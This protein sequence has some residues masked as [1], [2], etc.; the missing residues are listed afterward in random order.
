MSFLYD[1]FTSEILHKFINN[2]PFKQQKPRSPSKSPSK[3]STESSSKKGTPKS[4]KSPSK[5]SSPP[6][7]PS[8]QSKPTEEAESPAQLQETA[9]EEEAESPDA[10]GAESPDATETES[11]DAAE[12]ESPD[13]AEAES[14]DAAEA[15]ESELPQASPEE[16]DQ[17]QPP[18]EE[19]DELDLPPEESNQPDEAPE[20]P[21]EQ[22]EDSAEK[23]ETS[24]EKVE[25]IAKPPRHPRPPRDS[26][27][28]G[29]SC[30]ETEADECA[31]EQLGDMHFVYD[32]PCFANC[33]PYMDPVYKLYPDDCDTYCGPFTEIHWSEILIPKKV[34]LRSVKKSKPTTGEQLFAKMEPPQKGP[35]QEKQMQWTQGAPPTGDSPASELEINIGF[36]EIASTFMKVDGGADSQVT[37]SEIS[38]ISDVRMQI[39]RCPKDYGVTLYMPTVGSQPFVAA[40]PGTEQIAGLMVA[41]EPFTGPQESVKGPMKP[42]PMAR[43][44][45]TLDDRPMSASMPNM[46]VST[47]NSTEFRNTYPRA[48]NRPIAAD[49]YPQGQEQMMRAVDVEQVAIIQDLSTPAGSGAKNPPCYKCGRKVPDLQSDPPPEA[50]PPDKIKDELPK[51][52]EAEQP[53]ISPIAPEGSYTCQPCKTYLSRQADYPDMKAQYPLARAD[54]GNLS[55]F[56]VKS[57]D[58]R[59]KHGIPPPKYEDQQCAGLY[60]YTMPQMEERPSKISTL[61]AQNIQ[62]TARESTSSPGV[63][64]PSVRPPK[65]PGEEPQKIGSTAFTPQLVEGVGERKVCKATCKAKMKSERQS[66]EKTLEGVERKKKP[67]GGTCGKRK[68]EE[69]KTEPKPVEDLARDMKTAPTKSL[70]KGP[71]AQLINIQDITDKEMKSINEEIEKIKRKIQEMDIPELDNWRNVETKTCPSCM[72]DH[73]MRQYPAHSSGRHQYAAAPYMYPTGQYPNQYPYMPDYSMYGP[74]YTYPYYQSDDTED[75]DFVCSCSRRRPR[76]R[77][78]KKRKRRSSQSITSDISS[79]SGGSKRSRGSKSSKSSIGSASSKTQKK[80]KRRPS[81]QTTVSGV[82]SVSAGSGRSSKGSASLGELTSYRRKSEKS[83][84]QVSFQDT[85]CSTQTDTEPE[86]E[87]RVG[88]GPPRIKT[89]QNFKGFVSKDPH[90]NKFRVAVRIS[91]SKLRTYKRDDADAS[92][93][94]SQT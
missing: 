2:H 59:K 79:I 5:Q 14:P 64:K 60:T 41:V 76:T 42:Q 30:S 47:L 91:P 62:M 10:G 94:L 67:C 15:N 38:T 83:T 21:A 35:D 32:N 57:D 6:K 84:S 78:H 73:H 1:I 18:P 40:E 93:G 86:V 61:M 56:T 45:A 58:F 16:S 50:K 22:P 25:E 19:S 7:S 3:Q 11:P 26:S 34:R 17:Q 52:P 49:Y 20:L 46:S 68:A 88:K 4:P 12:T 27:S 77:R 23:D 8:N 39:K 89:K 66:E 85:G 70:C 31:D 75:M 72:Q 33:E 43:T 28:S 29:C 74:S 53:G 54:Y 71:C 80:G 36:T 69:I 44:N 81:S 9:L 87:I 92:S 90:K 65:L 51:V 63:T 24:P 37:V 13:A 48:M 82:S 55:T